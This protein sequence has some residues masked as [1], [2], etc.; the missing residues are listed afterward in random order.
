MNYDFKYNELLLEELKQCDD[1]LDCMFILRNRGVSISFEKSFIVHN[2][3]KVLFKNYANK[4]RKKHKFSAFIDFLRNEKVIKI[5]DY[6]STLWDAF[7][8]YNFNYIT[9]YLEAENEQNQ[10]S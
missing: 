7:L 1:I 2:I 5:D 3:V 8:K 4:D 10:D 6:D 9:K